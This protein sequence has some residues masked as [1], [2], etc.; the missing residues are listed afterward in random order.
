MGSLSGVQSA[1]DPITTEIIQNLFISAAHEMKINL[2]RAAYNPVVFEMYDFAVGIFDA[3]ANMLAQAPGLP[4]FL[5]TLRENVRVV[6]E[7]IGGLSKFRPGDVYL[8]NDPY[9]SGTHLLDVTCVAPVFDRDEVVGF[10]VAKTHWLDVG[11]KDP[12]SWS[13]DSKSI[14]HEGIRFRSVKLYDAGKPVEPVFQVIRYNVRLGES[15]LGDLRAQVAACRTGELRFRHILAKYGRETVLAAKGQFMD[16]A[17]RMARLAIDRIPDGVYQAEGSIDNDS[18]NLERKN[19]PVRVTVTVQ[20]SVMTVDLTGS[21]GQN[22]GPINCGLATTISAVR[23]GFKCVTTPWVPIN[24][25]SFRSL[26]VVVPDNSMFNAKY[27]APVCQFGM[28]LITMI[29]TFFKAL[30]PAMP[31][32]LPAGHYSDLGVLSMSGVDPRNGQEFI[33]VDS[34]SGGWGACEGR[35]GESCLIAIV[36][37]DSQNIPAEIVELRYP[38]RLVRFC[39]YEGSGGPGK[40]RGGLGHIRDFEALADELAVLTSIERHEYKPWGIFGGGEGAVNDAILNPGSPG[41]REV[42]KVT[43]FPLKR[44]DILSVRSGGGGGYGPAWTRDPARVLDDVLDA[45][46]SVAS[47]REDYKVSIDGRDG[48]WRID[49]AGT[50][51]LR[52]TAAADAEREEGA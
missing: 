12:G 9:T 11:G 28:H 17:E 4:V 46:V 37:G 20:G 6:T 50:K 5:G 14:Y 40:F 38:L 8:A 44:G 10:A 43:N 45:Y 15:V 26:N 42:R 48:A 18:L 22:E 27:P 7:D 39:L 49:E 36:D 34:S 16:Y 33:H 3:E 51:A 47:A 30:A 35:D 32:K 29:D 19:L 23:V 31:G 1:V 25:G 41:E 52:S 13:N 2:A 24:E 21:Q